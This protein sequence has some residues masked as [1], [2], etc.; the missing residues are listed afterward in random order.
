MNV[1]QT[2]CG[3]L[4]SFLQRHCP[5]PGILLAAIG[6]ERRVARLRDGERLCSRSDPAD[7][8]W[9]VEEG[10]FRIETEGVITARGPGEIIGELAFLR[11]GAEARRGTDVVADGRC[12]VW[13][14]DR[15]VIDALSVEARAL[16]FETISRAVALKLDEATEQRANFLREVGRAE[17]IVE[18][19]VC[20]EGVEATLAA[21][22]ADPDSAIATVKKTA[23]VWFS[24]VA[25]FSALSEQLSAQEVGELLRG[26][27]DPQVE[28]IE[29]AGGQIDKYMGD[30]IMAFWL[31]PDETRLRRAVAGAA[32]A[33]RLAVQKVRDFAQRS[34]L[35]LDI[36]IGLHAGE[37]AVGDFGG[38][39]RIAFTLV[40]Q[41]VNAAAR[42]EQYK[43][44]QGE[45]SGAVR[46]SDTVYGLLPSDG[47]EAFNPE[48]IV[49]ADKHDRH[50]TAYLSND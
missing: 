31:C 17:R 33:A 48:P 36:R 7:C 24:D 3:G 20:Q 45:K 29:L 14:I 10:R 11:Q 9:V 6:D 28:E 4:G 42:Y 32:G 13:R 1:F 41:V 27:I 44:K 19:L 46:L 47:R 16:W 35:P 8:L 23:L 25:G 40:G 22:S 26:V 43:P 15:T 37:V 30:G 5:H 12:K 49:F 18:R 21:L 34:A 2:S 39:Q 38:G 50:F